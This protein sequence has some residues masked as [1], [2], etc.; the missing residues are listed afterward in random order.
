MERRSDRRAWNGAA[1]VRQ[2][3]T[4][5]DRGDLPDG[6]LQGTDRG[7]PGLKAW[8]LTQHFDLAQLPL[9]RRG[10]QRFC[11]VSAASERGGLCAA[12]LKPAGQPDDQKITS[13]A[14]SVNRHDGCC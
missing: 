13:P 8:P 1:V 3:V 2:G 4:L 7:F 14:E 6:H 12:P 10:V 11:A 9:S 5:A